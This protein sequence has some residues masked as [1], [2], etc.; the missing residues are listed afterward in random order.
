MPDKKPVPEDWPPPELKSPT[1]EVDLADLW[2]A[3]GTLARV[4]LNADEKG[5]LRSLREA[6]YL[7]VFPPD[8]PAKD[9][10]ER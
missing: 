3:L 8:A 10:S 4:R 9:F 1:C 2:S 5:A 7:K 6:F